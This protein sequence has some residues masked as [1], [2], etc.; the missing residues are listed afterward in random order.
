MEMPS[1]EASKE[2]WR[3]WARQRRSDID[4]AT[5]SEGVNHGLAE[6]SVLAEGSKVLAFLPLADE[7]DLRPLFDSRSDCEFLATRTPDRGGRLTIHRLEDPLEVHRL[8]FLQPHRTASEVAPADVDVVLLPGLAFDLWGTR[9][10]RGAG[11]FDQLLVR[12]RPDA[13]L[14]GV[15][16][17]ELVVDRLP[18]EPHDVPV[19]YLATEEGVVAVAR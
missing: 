7:V 17:G 1:A 19:R 4:F 8:G 2:E 16:P 12:A 13:A 6:W 10:G 5:V 11:Y 9:L 14:V 15:T 3:S 18:G